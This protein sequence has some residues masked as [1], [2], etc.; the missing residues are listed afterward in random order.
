[1]DVNAPQLPED[2]AA[3]YDAHADFVWRS[4]RRLGVPEADAP[5]ALQEVFVVV[6][7]KLAT[8]ERRSTLTTWLFG[9][10]LRVAADRRKKASVRYERA[11]GDA[12]ADGTDDAR[13][14]ADEEL[15]RR[16]QLRLLE[17]ALD[18]LDDDQRTVFVLFELEELTGAAI[19]ELLAIPAG[20]VMSRLRLAREAFRREVGR[21]SAREGF[22][23]GPT[24]QGQARLPETP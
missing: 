24:T 15:V 6:H 3:V 18:K 14:G 10:C 2:L 1:V 23:A 11:D 20:T 19:A 13:P 8:F 5:D 17:A 7:R 12:T 21:L 4:L 22:A 9:I 16:D